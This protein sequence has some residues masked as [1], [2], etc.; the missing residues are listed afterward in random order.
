[1]ASAQ[2]EAVKNQ[3]REF[4]AGLDPNMGLEEMRASYE[5]FATLTT[6]PDGNSSS[7]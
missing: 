5:T 1:M 4:A 3:L 2:A 6:E 7:G